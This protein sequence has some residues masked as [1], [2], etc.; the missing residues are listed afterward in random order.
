MKL[1][2]S[3]YKHFYDAEMIYFVAVVT[4]LETDPV[5][6][7]QY[8]NTVALLKKG[9]SFGVSIFENSLLFSLAK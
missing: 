2:F 4:V 7:E 9:N 6:K 8:A 5:T 3:S 1:L